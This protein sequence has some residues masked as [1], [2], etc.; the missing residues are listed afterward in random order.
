MIASAA[1]ITAMMMTI[2][3][4][5]AAIAGLTS[6]SWTGSSGGRIGRLAALS[7]GSVLSVCPG[8]YFRP[9]Y[10]LM[11]VPC[12]ALW[13]AIGISAIVQRLYRGWNGGIR[14][15]AATSSFPTHYL[16]SCAMAAALAVGTSAWLESDYLFQPRVFM[17]L[18]NAQAVALPYDGVNPLPPRYCYLKPYYLDVET[19]YFDHLAQGAL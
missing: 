12:M 19:S 1:T 13:G 11:A 8:L 2:P 7:L 4:L 3:M 15:A 18:Q 16:A 9:H 17:E 5:M 10:F 6:L 14:G